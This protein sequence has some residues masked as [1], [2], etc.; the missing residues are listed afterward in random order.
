MLVPQK[1]YVGCME[2]TAN[3]NTVITTIAGHHMC[4]TPNRKEQKKETT[5]KI[6]KGN[7]EARILEGYRKGQKLNFGE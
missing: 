7:M 1:V 4:L 3:M 5:F 6:H 2:N